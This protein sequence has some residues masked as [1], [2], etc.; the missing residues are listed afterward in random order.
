[1]REVA[2]LPDS[3]Y[4]DW[5][6]CIVA[7]GGIAQL[8]LNQ[9]LRKISGVYPIDR[10]EAFF[11]A[12]VFPS[13]EKNFRM[14]LKSRM[15]KSPKKGLRAFAAEVLSLVTALLALC[16]AKLVPEAKLKKEVAAFVCLAKIIGILRCGDAARAKVELLAEL[17]KEHHRRF[18]ELYNLPKPKL[19]YMLHLPQCLARFLVNLNCF[20]AERKH[21]FT[22]RVGAFAHRHMVKTFAQRAAR[23]WIESLKDPMRMAPFALEGPK[24]QALGGA[25]LLC[26]HRHGVARPG[27]P[28]AAICQG[29]RL[30]TPRGRL[31]AKDVIAF[32]DLHGCACRGVAQSFVRMPTA[33]GEVEFY[34]IVIKLQHVG[35][36]CYKEPADDDAQII[37]VHQSNLRTACAW[38]RKADGLHIIDLGHCD[39]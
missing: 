14:R 9:F 22:N 37:P 32:R 39:V 28:A 13:G 38:Y 20:S 18:M 33:A 31:T 2:A 12:I 34:A 30:K 35:G 26:L 10:V 21:K 6:H 5:M 24:P 1:M 11:R 23:K 3:I 8:H 29:K 36:F 19:H 4:W 7:S 27:V 15:S 25:E 17:I 16:E